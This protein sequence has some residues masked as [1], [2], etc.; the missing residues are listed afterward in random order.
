MLP[1]ELIALQHNTS[2]QGKVPPV[3]F[4]RTSTYIYAL[5]GPDGQQDW[6]GWVRSRVL[7]VCD[8]E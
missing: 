7:A 8:H 2:D 5:V 4:W 3:A 1:R 6:Q